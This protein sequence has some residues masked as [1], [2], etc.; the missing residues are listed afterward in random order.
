MSNPPP[1]EPIKPS[2]DDVRRINMLNF[3]KHKVHTEPVRVFAYGS[4]IWNPCFEYDDRQPARLSGWARQICLWTISA[5]GSIDEPGLTF[6]LDAAPESFCDGV[7]FTLSKSNLLADLD[8]IWRREMHTAIYQPKWLSINGR[9]KKMNAIAFVVNHLH[10][11]YAGPIDPKTAAKYIMKA[12][13]SLGTCSDY[14]EETVIALKEFGL[15]D[16]VLSEMLRLLKI[17]E[18]GSRN[19]R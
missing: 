7:I 11:L 4:L 6:G 3:F 8:E 14:Y 17:G 1:T 10:K 9:T 12:S 18:K 13:G 15:N 5:R 2:N 19:Y 16:P